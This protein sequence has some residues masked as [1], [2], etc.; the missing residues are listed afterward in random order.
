[1]NDFQ[2]TT[3]PKVA[4]ITLTKAPDRPGIAA[5]IFGSLWSHGLNVQ[6]I[7]SSSGT[8]GKVNITFAID[9]NDLNHAIFE[10]KSI[11]EEIGA[12]GLDIDKKV[13]LITISHPRLAQTPGVGSRI[14]GTLSKV[15]INVEAVSS[16]SNSLTCMI[17]EGEL[18]QA[19]E[20]L[21]KEFA[22]P[23]AG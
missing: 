16:S 20:A 5:Q 7:V 14:F 8:E 15:K 22:L 1:M 2:L 11:K 13:A 21:Q 9:R 6:L 17:A 4:K 10:L 19:I 12:Q 23:K 18:P 3:N